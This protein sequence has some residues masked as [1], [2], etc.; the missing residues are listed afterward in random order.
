MI[1]DLVGAGHVHVDVDYLVIGAGTVGLLVATELAARG[2][3]VVCM[4]SGGRRQESETHPLNET[5]QDGPTRYAGAD[6]GRFR[7]LGGTSTRWGGALIPFQ[8]ADMEGANWP[9]GWDELTSYLPA[10]EALFGLPSGPYEDLSIPIG[11]DFIARLAKWPS[12]GKRNVYSLLRNKVD[13]TDG[14][15]VWINATATRFVV[16]GGRVQRVTAE[17]GEGSTLT[18]CAKEV[19]ICAGAIESTRLLLIMQNQNPDALNIPGL[20]EGLHDHLS[21]IVGEIEV[22][23]RKALNQL[24]GFRFASGG[25]M[26]N[27]RFELAPDSR[28]RKGISPCFAH[29]GFSQTDGGFAALR[30]VFRA[31]Q[32]RELPSASTWSRL[33][34]GS[35]WLTKALWWRLVHQRLLIPDGA[36]IQLHMVIE[37]HPDLRN[38]ITLSNKRQDRFGL[39]LAE[40]EW[41]VMPEDRRVMQSA[42]KAFASSWAASSLTSL[43]DIQ[44]ETE[45]G[46][47]KQMQS[48]GGIY[49]PGGTLSMCRI[50]DVPKQAIYRVAKEAENLSA[51]TTALL[52]TGG[53]ANPTMTLLQMSKRYLAAAC[54]DGMD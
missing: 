39:P 7:C 35:F 37:Q 5:V 44:L 3:R 10:V 45:L 25:C 17:S 13:G 32:Q 18:A 2:K 22:R 28:F 42:V 51:L 40:I 27:L 16:E 38:R 50:K 30:D 20:G 54:S 12:F 11:R 1:R 46:I 43:G 6:F 41:Q 24:V 34:K 23:D 8:A 53:G 9:D 14:P 26:R 19:V 29:I 4:E 52:P 21:A 48:G 49:H 15:E 36:R 31:L 47:W 33:L